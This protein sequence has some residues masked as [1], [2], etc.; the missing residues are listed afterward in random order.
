MAV[1]A[2]QTIVIEVQ[3]TTPVCEHTE[4]QHAP[5]QANSLQASGVSGRG[6]NEGR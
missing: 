4:D 1:A 5:G 6:W 2:V 3:Q